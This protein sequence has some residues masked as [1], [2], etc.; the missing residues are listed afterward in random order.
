M[1]EDVIMI[2]KICTTASILGAVCV[3]VGASGAANAVWSI[4]NIGLVWHNHRTGERAQAAMFTVFWILAVLG[5][6]KEAV[7]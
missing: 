3:S 5:V 4:S 7:K 2:T 1:D 6:F